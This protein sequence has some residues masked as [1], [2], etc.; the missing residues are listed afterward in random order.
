MESLNGAPTA[1]EDRFKQQVMAYLAASKVAPDRRADLADQVIAALPGGLDGPHLWLA[2]Q[3]LTDAALAR[4]EGLGAIEDYR[5]LARARLG[6][7]LA[8]EGTRPRGTSA[9]TGLPLDSPLSED[10]R[11]S[12]PRP[13]RREMRSQAL[14]FW[15]PN[16]GRSLKRMLRFGSSLEPKA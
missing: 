5:L 12:V 6:A 15:M 3:R 4:D 8:P 10:D 1:P 16:A 13:V 14:A 7:V 9:D 2:I 11:Y